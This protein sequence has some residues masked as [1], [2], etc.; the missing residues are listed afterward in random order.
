ML[1]FE[2]GGCL[3]APP[4]SAAVENKR[5]CSFSR[6]VVVCQH[7]PSPALEDEHKC[8]SSRV[9]VVFQHPH[10]HAGCLPAPPPSTP[11]TTENE[12]PR[13]CFWS[14]WTQHLAISP[15]LK[16]S[17]WMLVFGCCGP[18]TSP[19]HHSPF[20]HP[21]PLIFPFSYHSHCSSILNN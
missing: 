10:A 9:V 1:V 16:T 7:P 21:P 19:H 5:S 14:L 12:H 6:V 18:S 17:M 4:P 11:T 8:S 2:G 20:H 3:P 15:P 13:A